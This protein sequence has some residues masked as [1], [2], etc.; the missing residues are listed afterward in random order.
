M[1]LLELP[2]SEGGKKRNAAKNMSISAY[3]LNRKKSNL[4]LSSQKVKSPN[5][6]IFEKG[7]KNIDRDLQIARESGYKLQIDQLNTQLTQL[8]K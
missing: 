3:G 7:D 4:S 2:K 1:S 5:G 8:K 6:D